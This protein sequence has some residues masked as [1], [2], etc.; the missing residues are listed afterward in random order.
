[1]AEEAVEGEHPGVVTA[2]V[3]LEICAAGKGRTYANDQ[4]SG[5][6]GGD[7]DVLDAEVFL[8]A[9]DRGSHG[10]AEGLA[11]IDW[12]WRRAHPI[13]FSSLGLSGRGAESS[14]QLQ[15]NLHLIP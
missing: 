11:V 8:P 3:D 12:I 4:L 14:D 5:S 15:G 13:I 7:R 2:A 6:C 10:S 9:Q 1:V